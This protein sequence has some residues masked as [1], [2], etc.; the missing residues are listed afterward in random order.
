M[1]LRYSPGSPAND[2][3]VSAEDE[4]SP[5]RKP[6]L[7]E[8]QKLSLD[9]QVVERPKSQQRRVAKA[10]HTASD[11]SLDQRRATVSVD[12]PAIRPECVPPTPRY[13]TT[14]EHPSAR[15]TLPQK[16]NQPK[17]DTKQQL[18]QRQVSTLNVSLLPA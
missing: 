6:L 10:L 4:R 8:K 15:P 17:R 1:P 9:S 11:P 2:A 5:Q 13:K 12:E 14:L 7:Q 3:D 18:Q 16:A